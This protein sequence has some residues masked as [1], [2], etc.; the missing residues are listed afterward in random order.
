MGAWDVG[1]FDN[2]EAMDWVTQ[3]DEIYDL[4]ILKE[5]FIPI[6]KSL[7]YLETPECESGLAC[8][9]VIAALNK[10]PLAKL[11]SEVTHFVSRI[12]IMPSAELLETA[13]TAVE[14]I[15]TKSELRE[16]WNDSP[17]CSRWL[18]DIEN[19]QKRLK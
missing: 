16:L 3:L 19:L 13:L 7:K 4:E 17:D 5:T 1:S 11:P 10:K 6:I 8:A 15:K 18:A 12:G 2:D 14:H 9:E